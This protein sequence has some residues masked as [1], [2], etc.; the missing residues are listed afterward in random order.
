MLVSACGIAFH[1]LLDH[2]QGFFVVPGNTCTGSIK[3]VKLGK[4][5]I[6]TLGY[7]IIIV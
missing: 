3:L 2:G 5:Y 7:F 1:F 6:T 4:T